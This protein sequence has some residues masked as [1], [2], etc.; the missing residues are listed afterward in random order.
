MKLLEDTWLARTFSE[1]AFRLPTSFLPAIAAIE[2]SDLL[3]TSERVPR[4]SQFQ[5]ETRLFGPGLIGAR[6]QPERVLITVESLMGSPHLRQDGSFVT[7]RVFGARVELERVVK[8][9]ESLLLS[10]GA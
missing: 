10:P 8:A 7:P 1:L 6:V 4:S 5:Q 9:I 2:L 3:I